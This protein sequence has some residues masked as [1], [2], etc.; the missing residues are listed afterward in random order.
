MYIGFDCVHVYMEIYYDYKA[1]MYLD[2]FV[3]QR[4]VSLLFCVI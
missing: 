4:G 1:W 3:Y 2:A